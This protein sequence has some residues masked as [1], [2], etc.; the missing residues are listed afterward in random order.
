LF[1]IRKN[2]K[3]MRL[4]TALSDSRRSPTLQ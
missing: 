1:N 4:Q 3:D 2:V